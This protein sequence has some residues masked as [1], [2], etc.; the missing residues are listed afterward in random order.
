MRD[1]KYAMLNGAN[2]KVLLGYQASEY[3]LTKAHYLYHNTDLSSTRP[4]TMI[5]VLY[6]FVLE[7]FEFATLILFMLRF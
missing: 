4:L 1:A 3:Y 2:V 7:R 6:S 5:L